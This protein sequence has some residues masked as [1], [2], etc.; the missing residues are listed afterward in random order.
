VPWY[1][2]RALTR[3]NNF[4]N[5]TS[6]L[7]YAQ[8][9]AEIDAGRVVGARVG[10]NG[11]GGHFMV[12]YGY[13]TSGGIQYY[14]IDDPIYGKSH[15]TVTDFSNNYQG[16]GTWTHAYYTKS[17]IPNMHIK[18]LILK[19]LFMRKIWEE[20][21][22][23]AV[24]AGLQSEVSQTTQSTS[25]SLAHRVYSLGVKEL[26]EGNA[27]PHE[28]NVRV[29]E[30]ENDKPSAYFDIAGT[31]IPTVQQMSASSPY[32]AL[33]PRALEQALALPEQAEPSEARLLR[34]PALNF[35][36]L[37][38]HGD[39]EAEDQLIPL[40]NFHG[41]TEFKAIPYSEAIERL[42]DPAREIAKQ[43]DTTGA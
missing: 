18:P 3:T 19:D 38:L 43:I 36:A 37:W 11:G 30:M 13:A 16:S 7:T 15:L 34:I 5:I 40:R 33:Y 6:P 42:R 29:I 35:E 27:E 4:I 20:R 39:N 2:D 8:V 21:P 9:K 22:L 12:I 28:T 31:E 10:W 23:L 41:F 14:D 24:K 17:Y 32:L 26:A 25:L 1:L